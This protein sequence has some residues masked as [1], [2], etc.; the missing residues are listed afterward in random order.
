MV[1]KRGLAVNWC[2]PRPPGPSA[3]P[4]VGHTGWPDATPGSACPPVDRSCTGWIRPRGQR[5][6]VLWSAGA[7]SPLKQ[8]SEAEGAPD[9]RTETPIGPRGS[10]TGVTPSCICPG[11]RTAHPTDRLTQPGP[12]PP[13]VI[14]EGR[15]QDRPMRGDAAQVG[16]VGRDDQPATHGGRL[17]VALGSDPGGE[18]CLAVERPDQLA[19]ID[20]SVFSS[21]TRSERVGA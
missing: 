2:V 18:P 15:A 10:R 13:A 14:R 3:S 6:G 11:R 20:E 7:L 16:L 9:L 1:R 5:E 21:M 12:H 19:N 17:P 4:K 8:S